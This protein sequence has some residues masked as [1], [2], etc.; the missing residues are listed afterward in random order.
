MTLL[1]SKNRVNPRFEKTLLDKPEQLKK[2]YLW[3][4]ANEKQLKKRYLNKYIAVRNQ[5]VMF[6]SDD[7]EARLK[8][9]IK[10]NEEVGS[11]TIKKVAKEQTCLLFHS[12]LFK[13]YE[14][15]VFFGQ[16]S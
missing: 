11:F 2:E 9:L 6:E 12:M 10:L 15:T 3:I 1:L 4:T 16:Q 14:F 7:Y 8:V 5:R 13:N